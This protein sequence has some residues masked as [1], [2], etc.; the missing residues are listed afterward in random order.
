MVAPE[1]RPTL[2]VAAAVSL[3]EVM[4]EIEAGF[5]S[6]HDI[7][8]RLVLGS[9][10]DLCRQIVDGASID[11]FIS[12]SH[13]EV[14]HLEQTGR[15]EPRDRFDLVRNRLVL[16]VPA[17][18][19]AKLA[20]LAD[21]KLEGVRRVA[22]G[23]PDSVPAGRYAKQALDAARLTTSLA[24]KLIYGNDVRQVLAYVVR[25]EVDAGLVYQTDA[26]A[27]GENVRVIQTVD[28]SLHDPVVYPLAI[29]GSSDS[30][31]RAEAFARFV[32]TDEAMKIFLDHG[33]L[34]TDAPATQTTR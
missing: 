3:R 21:L 12:A 6:S 11:V 16:I 2:D 19:R 26:R 18:S 27:A 15:I 8:V 13:L 14:D 20:R 7:D 29:V 5:E 25:G 17:D 34:A 33:F 23:D 10:S 22:M 24:D 28:E 1:A 30:R 32:R 4:R 31:S 9:S